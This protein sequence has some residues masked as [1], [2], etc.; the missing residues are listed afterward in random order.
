MKDYHAYIALVLL[1]LS[2]PIIRLFSSSPP[3]GLLSVDSVSSTMINARGQ[4]ISRQ[5][6]K[7][8]FWFPFIFSGMPSTLMVDPPA[9][10]SLIKDFIGI[11]LWTVLGLAWNGRWWA[12]LGFALL[13]VFCGFGGGLMVWGMLF[14]S[15]YGDRLR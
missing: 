8:S 2:V 11:G 12:G 14:I 4:E 7:F 1:I 5:E 3:M 9:P 15:V 10:G 13:N 6:G